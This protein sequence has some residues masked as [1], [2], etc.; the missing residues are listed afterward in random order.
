MDDYSQIG[1]TV[2]EYA[3]EKLGIPELSEL[4]AKKRTKVLNKYKKDLLEALEKFVDR[5]GLA[6]SGMVKTKNKTQIL[7]L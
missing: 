2:K 4:K 3:A 7:N 1:L 5:C 6:F